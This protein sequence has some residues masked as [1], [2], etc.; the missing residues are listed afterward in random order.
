MKAKILKIIPTAATLAVMGLIFFF[1]SQTQEE[2]SDL[3]TGLLRTLIDLLPWTAHAD[4]G[5]KERYILSMHHFIRKCAHFTIYAAL[6]FCA[7]SMLKTNTLLKKSGCIALAAT[8]IGCVYAAS[9]EFH[10]SLTDGRGPLVSDVILDTVG[11]LAGA[12]VFIVLTLIYS[13]IKERSSD[14]KND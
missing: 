12:A 3:S 6:G 11:T 8:V 10:Q 4:A 5:Q 14:Y 1:S 9:D 2:S 7:A 13:R